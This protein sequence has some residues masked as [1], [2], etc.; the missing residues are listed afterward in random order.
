MYFFKS[1]CETYCPLNSY[2]DN[3]KMICHEKKN[4][5]ITHM[6]LPYQDKFSFS[7]YNNDLIAFIY[8][9][10]S[11]NN[12]KILNIDKIKCILGSSNNIILEK[13]NL[14]FRK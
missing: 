7:S 11:N 8:A 2:E 10:E 14:R 5:I 6:N 4:K 13:K 9:Y 3:V 1:N 12:G